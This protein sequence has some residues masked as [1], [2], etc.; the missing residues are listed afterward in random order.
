MLKLYAVLLFS[1]SVLLVKS[2]PIIAFQP[3]ITGLS[4]PVD[5]VNANDGS[6]RLYIAQQNGTILLWNGTST[7]TFL[8]VSSVLTSPA[9][10]EQGLLSIA[11][12]PDYSTNRYF[13]I[14]YTNSAG[15]VTLARYQRN[16]VNPLIADLSS[17]TVLLT[18]PKPGSPYYTNHNGGKL[19]FGPDGYLYFAP[20]DGGSGGDPFNNAQDLT[21]LRGKMLRIDVNAFT[22]PPYYTIPPTNPF[23]STGG[24]VRPE[25]Y[26]YGLRN[27]WRWSF[28]KLNGDM[29]IGD[30]GQSNYEEVNYIPAA[31]TN[32]KNFGWRC[33]E[34]L[35]VYN[36]SGCSGSYT[37]PIFEY[38]HNNATGGYSIT[39]GVVYRGSEFPSLYGTYVTADYVTG[40]FWQIKSNGSGGWSSVLQ[41]GLNGSIACFAEGE[42][43]TLYAVRR[44]SSNAIV[45][46]VNVASVVPLVLNNFSAQY[47]NGF[48]DVQWNTSQEQDITSFVVQYSED[49]RSFVDAG[50]IMPN[51]NNRDNNYSF[52][53]NDYFEGT[54]YYRLA[55]LTRNNSISYSAIK[56]VT[57]MPVP[58]KI[59]SNIVSNKRLSITVNSSINGIQIVNSMGSLVYKYEAP[60]NI[61]MQNVSLPDLPAGHYVAIFRGKQTVREKFVIMK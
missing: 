56:R 7:S 10:G 21:T 25:I 9:A 16:A 39:G 11:F 45:Y 33:R 5:V 14:Y 29:W 51:N 1:F 6:N 58:V 43:G 36:A 24:G 41:T 3:V 47:V 23:A 35:H 52:R 18:I 61:G 2:Q 60:L 28:D 50:T 37:D 13:F 26:Q 46:K 44:V 54:R 59:N 40:N 27:P 49:N 32:G 20:G 48:T 42:D 53:H 22:T 17:G 34:G 30:V 55:I 38:T 8:N 57:G 31:S 15:D 12:H 4:N 19:N